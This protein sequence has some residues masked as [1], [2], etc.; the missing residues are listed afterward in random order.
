M[1]IL[2][3]FKS[4]FLVG[5]KFLLGWDSNHNL[6]LS[7][8]S[9]CILSTWLWPLSY[10]EAMTL[11]VEPHS[12]YLYTNLLLRMKI[13]PSKKSLKQYS[14]SRWSLLRS[15][16]RIAQKKSEC[17]LITAKIIYQYQWIITFQLF[18]SKIVNENLWRVR[19]TLSSLGTLIPGASFIFF[20][21]FV[22]F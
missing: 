1:E 14:H 16:I 11:S 13:K 10:R 12:R 6:R 2:F 4:M 9:S 7:R 21:F 8:R 3:F 19:S 22:I 15:S 18:A 5:A 17:L 20:I